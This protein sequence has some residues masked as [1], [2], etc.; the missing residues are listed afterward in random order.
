MLSYR[1]C[2]TF[3]QKEEVDTK[4]GFL[5]AIFFFIT[6]TTLTYGHPPSKVNVSVEGKTVNALITHG[7]LGPAHHCVNKILVF[8][9]SDKIIE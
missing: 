9:N 6:S 5:L 8:L 7:V 2:Y 3:T 4:K 1:N